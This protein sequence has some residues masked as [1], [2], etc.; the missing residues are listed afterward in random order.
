MKVRFSGE[1]GDLGTD[2]GLWCLISTSGGR[3]YRRFLGD[4]HTASRSSLLFSR[5]TAR[6]RHTASN[7]IC[8]HEPCTN[9]GTQRPLSPS[10]QFLPQG[11]LDPI[12][13]TGGLS[14]VR[15]KMEGS[16]VLIISVREQKKKFKLLSP[17]YILP[18]WGE[19]GE[20][21][22]IWITFSGSFSCLSRR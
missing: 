22:D 1:A 2:E 4:N 13:L 6:Q 12:T 19:G 7:T 8:G 17:S 10:T 5:R 16:F 20:G 21:G 14:I 3:N 9:P 15:P 18:R 11:R